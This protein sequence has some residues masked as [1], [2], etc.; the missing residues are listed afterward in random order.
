MS[1]CSGIAAKELQSGYY[2]KETLS[3]T[4]YPYCDDLI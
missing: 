1:Q 4:I 3:W 2:N